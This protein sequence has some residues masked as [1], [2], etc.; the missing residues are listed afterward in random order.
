MKRFVLIIIVFLAFALQSQIFAASASTN[1]EEAASALANAEKAVASAYNATVNAEQ[2]G[3]NVSSLLVQLNDAGDQLGKAEISYSQGDF[4]ATLNL[5]NL[6][7]ETAAGVKAKAVQLKL[8][9][10]EARSVDIWFRMGVSIVAMVGVGLG[11]LGAW[12]FF[13]K[14]YYRRVLR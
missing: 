3:A 6:S 11:G 14:R 10:L 8:E 12:H 5:V 2:I 4:N 13:K 1:E 9:A 7:S